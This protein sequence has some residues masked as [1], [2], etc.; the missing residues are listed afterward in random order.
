MTNNTTIVTKTDNTE[1]K[2]Y[3]IKFDSIEKANNWLINQDSIVI[4]S[5]DL[6]TATQFSFPA[7]NIVV[8]QVRIEYIQYPHKVNN[9]YGIDELTHSSLYIS[10]K[11][12]SLRNKWIQRNPDKKYVYCVKSTT[13]R[14]LMGTSVGFISFVKDKLVVLFKY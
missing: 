3:F 8:T 12:E 13:R 4:T 2:Q 5:M 9:T 14:H 11:I 6:S 1:V 10:S 7:N